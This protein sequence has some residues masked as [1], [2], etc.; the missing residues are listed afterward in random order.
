MPAK[1][2]RFVFRE[3]LYIFTRIRTRMNHGCT[4]FVW[5]YRVSPTG[6]SRLGWELLLWRS[7]WAIWFIRQSDITVWFL[8]RN[9]LKYNEH[10]LLYPIHPP[11]LY[12][13]FTPSHLQKDR[14]DSH[15]NRNP[16]THVLRRTTGK[17]RLG[18]SGTARG[19]RHPRCSAS[20]S[21]V[22]GR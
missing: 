13:T 19:N 9:I 15:S 10:T 4:D 2:Y 11:S 12:T 16:T 22:Q 17:Q 20:G 18:S 5:H 3:L 6:S 7:D 1:A 21:G 8:P 14:S